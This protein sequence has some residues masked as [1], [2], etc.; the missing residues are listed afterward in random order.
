MAVIPP[1]VSEINQI[2]DILAW[3]GFNESTH[4]NS[5]IKDAFTTFDDNLDL[6]EKD[7]KDLSES[8]VVVQ[9]I[10]EELMSAS[11]KLKN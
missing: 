8:L 6:D 4:R 7:I 11:V 1:V 2:C 9:Q 10:I 3:I 5:I